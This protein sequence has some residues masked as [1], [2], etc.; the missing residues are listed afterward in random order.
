MSE[1]T[2]AAAH[3]AAEATDEATDE[4]TYL[5]TLHGLWKKAWPAGANTAPHYPHGE[6]PVTEY[7]RT[8]ARLQTGR[9]SGATT[10]SAPNCS[11]GAGRWRCGRWTVS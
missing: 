6:Q 8:W 10:A 4:A 11:S 2:H 7:L 1:S 3:A 5:A 9:C